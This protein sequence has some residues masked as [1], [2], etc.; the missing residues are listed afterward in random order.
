MLLAG[1]ISTASKSRKNERTE[2]RL[3][4]KAISQCGSGGLENYKPSRPNTAKTK[5]QGQL[6]VI[7]YSHI[8]V[9]SEKISMTL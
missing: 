1:L 3:E 9:P 2:T 8:T 5:L 7:E 6:D 4:M